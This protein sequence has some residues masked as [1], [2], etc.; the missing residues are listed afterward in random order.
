MVVALTLEAMV[1]ELLLP[2][3]GVEAVVS[4]PLVGLIQDL[5]LMGGITIPHMNHNYHQEL[6]AMVFVK[7]GQ[8]QCQKQLD[9]ICPV[10]LVEVQLEIMIHVTCLLVLEVGTV[11]PVGTSMTPFTTLDL[12]E[13]LLTMGRHKSTNQT[14]G[15][16]MAQS[17]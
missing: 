11:E 12:A 3:A 5:L 13:V 8:V 17:L 16:G 2:L 7:G 14:H 9:F 10:V 6:A 15:M 1:M 4:I